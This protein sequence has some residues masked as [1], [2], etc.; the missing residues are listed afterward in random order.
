[1]YLNDILYNNEGS[2]SATFHCVKNLGIAGKH[3]ITLYVKGNGTQPAN[4]QKIPE[5]TLGKIFLS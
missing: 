2:D 4:S 5:N 1:M 3:N